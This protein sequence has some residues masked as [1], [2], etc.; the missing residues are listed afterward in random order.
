MPDAQQPG[1]STRFELDEHVDVALRPEVLPQRRTEYREPPDPVFPTECGKGLTGYRYLCVHRDSLRF[2]HHDGMIQTHVQLTEEQA[3]AL[4]DLA[5]AEERS[6]SELGR[7]CVTEYLARR[8]APDVRD[9]AE[10]ARSLKGRFRSDHP[11]LA[12][13]HDLFLDDAFDT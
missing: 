4:K 6:I 2:W 5:Q 1:G 11:D 8:R 3:R 12:E 13:S 7:E 9:L 10:R